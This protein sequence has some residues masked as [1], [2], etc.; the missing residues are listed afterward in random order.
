MSAIKNEMPILAK[1]EGVWEGYYRHLDTE[2][3]IIDTH[4]SRL[5]CR[6]APE[7]GE[8][9]YHQTNIYSWDDGKREVREFPVKYTPGS[10][11]MVFTGEIDGWAKEIS[12]DPAS[13]TLM[14]WWQRR[15]FPDIYFYE[16]INASD[17]GRQRS[18]IWQWIRNGRIFR[19]TVIDE[20]KI[21][22]TVR[23][24]EQS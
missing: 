2:G 1:H 23:G 14:L 3:R 18:R 22:D 24:Y 21:S 16:M 11:T 12:E 10:K 8:W 4:R 7:A 6:F 20:L 19:R 17:D 9:D 5:L 13:R 15:E